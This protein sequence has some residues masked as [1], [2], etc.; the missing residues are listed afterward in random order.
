MD[1]LDK[2][3]KILNEKVFQE[4]IRKA[5]HHNLQKKIF[6]LNQ[7]LQ[8]NIKVNRIIRE[9]LNVLKD[10]IKYKYRYKFSEKIVLSK[11]EIEEIKNKKWN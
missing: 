11:E 6:D 10:T 8:E 7:Q 9:Q 2:K 1:I 4:E 3:T 5:N